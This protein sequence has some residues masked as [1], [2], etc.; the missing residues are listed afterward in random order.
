MHQAERNEK[1]IS[2]V[3]RGT[4]SSLIAMLV[5]VLLFA[6]V[7]KF[8]YIDSSIIK[9][10]NQFIKALSVFLGCFFSVRGSKGLIKGL[11]IGFTSSALISLI[12]ALFGGGISFGISFFIDLL[13]MSVIG[14]ISG[15]I[16]VN[17]KK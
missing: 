10:V 8:A 9:T 17:V 1:I 12:F 5:A 2:N 11:L 6:V 4:L 3:I 16:V 7:V 13:F 15:I 14:L